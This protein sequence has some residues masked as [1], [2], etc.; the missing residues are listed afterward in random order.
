MRTLFI[1]FFIL[2]QSNLQAMTIKYQL[3]FPDPH[4]HNTYVTMTISQINQPELEVSMPVWTPGSYML[5]EYA[6]HIDQ[7]DVLDGNDK[8]VAFD[9][10][11]KNTWQLETEGVSKVVIQYRVYC[12]LATVRTNFVDADH[13][14]L[15]GA[16]TFLYV[17]G[18]QDLPV[19]VTVKPNKSW[20]QIATPMSQKGKNKW[21]RT[22]KNYDELVDSPI[23]VGNFETYNF[24]AGGIP[25]EVAI[26]GD[27]N[28]DNKRFVKDLTKVCQV[29][30]DVF[31]GH[32]CD[33]YLFIIH[34][35]ENRYNGL[36]HSHSTVCQ[37]PRW[38]YFPHSKYCR[39]MGLMSHE[40]FHLW[41]IKRIRPAAL[42]SFDYNQ[43]NYTKQL[44]IAEGV[45][46]YY[47]DYIV[48]LSDIFTKEQYLNAVAK[49]INTVVNNPGDEVQSLTEASHDAWIK[50][51]RQNEN[52]VNN[53]VSYYTKGATTVM[54]L[55]FI[56]MNAT[57]GKKSFQDVMRKLYADY[58][59][60]PEEGYT[61]KEFLS[62]VEG[63]AGIQLD[64]FFQ[65][66]IYGKEPIDYAKYLDLM[67]LE[68]EDQNADNVAVDL[69]M[70]VNWEEG[71][72]LVKKVKAGFGAFESG[73]NVNDEII[74]INDYRVFKDYEKIL[75]QSRIGDKAEFLIDRGGKIRTIEVNL[76]A[77]ANVKYKIVEKKR[78]GKLA[79]QLRAKWLPQE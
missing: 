72:L 13:A 71:R 4:T 17:E 78:A 27:N 28:G 57:K 64:D 67:G 68:L 22:A 9:K 40:Y 12:F 60:N 39:T 37:V 55:D 24:K 3:S 46:S 23:E 56:I 36:E 20:K 63:V 52:S 69:G 29:T 2:T 62:V 54:V 47:D 66:H 35:T 33:D 65:R 30:T 21:V 18:Q 77:N 70:S 32:P 41:N 10:V 38:D 58:L 8:N 61:E 26:F 42:E 51:Y 76:T 7:F 6:Q 16:P 59:A 1:L 49:N 75:A 5:R 73:L 11:D 45:T 74:A 79:K 48:Y 34:N 44:W 25:H 19:E 15:N 53:L 31:G 14:A 43:E 50:Y